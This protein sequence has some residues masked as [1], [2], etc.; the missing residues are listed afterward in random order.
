M[1]NKTTVQYNTIIERK[2]ELELEHGNSLNKSQNHFKQQNN[3]KIQFK[4]GRKKE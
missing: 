3:Y 4:I 2:L 1:L